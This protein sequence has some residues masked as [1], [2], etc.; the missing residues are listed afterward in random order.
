MPPDRTQRYIKR[1][2][3]SSATLSLLEGMLAAVRGC[4]SCLAVLQHAQN[5]CFGSASWDDARVRPVGRRVFGFGCMS[6]A[7]IGP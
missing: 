3:M 6:V 1:S 4:A 2:C 5:P 7:A